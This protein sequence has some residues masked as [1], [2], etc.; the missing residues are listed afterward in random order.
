MEIATYLLKNVDDDDDD[1]KSGCFLR[2]TTQFFLAF[3][4][5]D[6]LF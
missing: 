1:G 6:C 4:L 3:C 5:Q 2:L